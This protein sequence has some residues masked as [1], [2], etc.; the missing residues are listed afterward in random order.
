MVS[1]VVMALVFKKNPNC[2]SLNFNKSKS[3][4]SLLTKLKPNQDSSNF[5]T[6]N[7]QEISSRDDS[8]IKEAQHF[9]NT[10]NNSK[11]RIHDVE[12]INSNLQLLLQNSAQCEPNVS[13]DFFLEQTLS[14]QNSLQKKLMFNNTNTWFNLLDW[15]LEYTSVSSVLSDLSHFK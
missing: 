5:N 9:L 15:K 2:L 6:Q 1:V 4:E 3:R 14:L 7:S 13:N 11:G 10:Y 8:T 12:K